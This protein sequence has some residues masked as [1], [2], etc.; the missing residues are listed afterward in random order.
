[1]G[2]HSSAGRALQCVNAGATGLN[3]IEAS[4]DFFGGLLRNCLNCDS[5]VMVTYSFHLLSVV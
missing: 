5:T 3:P 2:L 4:K 1:M